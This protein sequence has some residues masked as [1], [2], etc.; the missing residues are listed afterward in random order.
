MKT[1]T[2]SQMGK[3]QGGKKWNWETF[4]CSTAGVVIS[5]AIGAFFVPFGFI[6]AIVFTTVCQVGDTYGWDN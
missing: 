1:L 4:A 2:F 3:L 5:G 6:S